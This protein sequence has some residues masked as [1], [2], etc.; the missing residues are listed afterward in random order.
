MALNQFFACEYGRTRV[1]IDF[2][3]TNPLTPKSGDFTA[4]T[5]AI[6]QSVPR[7]QSLPGNGTDLVDVLKKAAALPVKAPFLALL[8]ADACFSAF[9]MLSATNVH[10]PAIEI[11]SLLEV[12]RVVL[13]AVKFL[14]T[15]GQAWWN[16]VFTPFHSVCV[17]LTIGSSESLA[18]IPHATKL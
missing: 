1:H 9:R 14:R 8:R 17:L 12:I 7:T 16:I 2:V 6:L 4:E 5:V 3:G 11:A 13:D 10:L 18:M 15:T